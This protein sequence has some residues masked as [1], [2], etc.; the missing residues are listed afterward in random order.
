VALNSIQ[1][2]VTVAVVIGVIVV[3][4][5]ILASVRRLDLTPEQ[6]QR[7]RNAVHYSMVIFLAACLVV[8]WAEELRS[9]A[10]VASAFAVAIVLSFKELL[11]CVAG[12]WLKTTAGAYRIGDRVRIG[13][14]SGDILDYGIL[15]TT[16]MEVGRTAGGDE[17]R[18]G[19][20]ITVPNSVLLTSTV[21]NLTHSLSFSWRAFDFYVDQGEDWQRLEKRLLGA[22]QEEIADYT[23]AMEA[24]LNHME[25]ELAFHRIG[26]EP[27]VLVSACSDGRIRLT[28]RVGLPVHGLRRARDRIS[29]RFLKREH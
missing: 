26:P 6:R 25:Q 13:D 7:T 27:E 4:L 16:L 21:C 19:T 1:T 17:L 3:A 28:L 20:V 2:L 22:A 10:L 5:A 11:M 18:S 29:R 9:A 15:S 14:V 12:W 24:E 8:V 23:G